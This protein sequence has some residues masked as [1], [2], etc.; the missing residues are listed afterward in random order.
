MGIIASHSAALRV[1]LFILL[2]YGWHIC[3]YAQSNYPYNYQCAEKGFQVSEDARRYVES[4]YSANSPDQTAIDS[5]G[6]E[7]PESTYRAPDL[8]VQ[9]DG[10]NARYFVL[11]GSALVKA[12]RDE[13]LNCDKAR[14]LKEVRRLFTEL[15]VLTGGFAVDEFYIQSLSPDD[16]L[17]LETTSFEVSMVQIINGLEAG[18]ADVFIN[19]NDEVTAVIVRYINSDQPNANPKN[20][21]TEAQLISIAKKAL[22][23][24]VDPE[25]RTKALLPINDDGVVAPF[26]YFS[27]GRQ[28]AQ[29]N[30]ISGEVEVSDNRRH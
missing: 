15:E 6:A 5:G 10:P 24:A 25:L 18:R 14:H 27:G 17:N 2:F 29:V 23:K 13:F 3:V 28:T 7:L 21:L 1:K 19:R 16:V 26:Y 11:S 22:A 4:V 30:A 8:R 9:L 20:W 12:D